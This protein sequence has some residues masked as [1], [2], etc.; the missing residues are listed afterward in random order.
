[1]AWRR[2]RD[3]GVLFVGMNVRDSKRNVRA[4]LW[5]F[6]VT[7]PNRPDPTGGILI[8]DGVN[9]I[10]EN[11]LVDREGQLARRWIGPPT[12]GQLEAFLKGLLP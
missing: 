1:M 12:E 8:E 6:G 10:P 5:Q 2:Y 4:F 11:Y 9:G 3:R 7:Y